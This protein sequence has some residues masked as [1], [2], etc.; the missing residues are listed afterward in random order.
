MIRVPAAQ[1]QYSDPVLQQFF[2]DHQAGLCT[3]EIVNTEQRTILQKIYELGKPDREVSTTVQHH[4]VH[5]QYAD[6]ELE[7]ERRLSV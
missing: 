2:L 7:F 4:A 1:V 3:F 5:V 6:P